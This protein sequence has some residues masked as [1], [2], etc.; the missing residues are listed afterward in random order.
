M[1]TLVW[2]EFHDDFSSQAKNVTGL[3]QNP[4]LNWS[5]NTLK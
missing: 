2:D 3:P 4:I 5:Q 1:G